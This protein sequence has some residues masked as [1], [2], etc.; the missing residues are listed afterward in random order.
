MARLQD[1]Y[2]HVR[3]LGNGSYG[4]VDLWR[5]RRFN[6]DFVVAKR[7]SIDGLTSEQEAAA[8][9]ESK[10]LR[11]LR[12]PHIVRYLS[13]W[14]DRAE[15]ELVIV[16]E[17]LSGGDLAKAIKA[18]GERQHRFEEARVL[19]WFAQL[20][21]ALQYC[22]AQSL[23]HRDL[24]P[25]NVFLSGDLDGAHLG[26][27]GV[28]KPLASGTGLTDTYV[29][30]H[31]YMSPEILQKGAYGLK[32]DVW[33]L[34]SIFYEVCALARPFETPEGTTFSTLEAIVSSEGPRP[35]P[36]ATGYQP[37]LEAM[38]RRMLDKSAASR[39]SLGQLLQQHTVLRTA[40]IQLEFRLGWEPS[41]MPEPEPEAAG[42]GA[43]DA[44]APDRGGESS[45]QDAKSDE[46]QSPATSSR[47]L[48]RRSS[49]D[50]DGQLSYLQLSETSKEVQELLEAHAR[51]PRTPT[52]RWPGTSCSREPEVAPEQRPDPQPPPDGA[53]DW[54]DL[55]EQLP[56][57]EPGSNGDLTASPATDLAQQPKPERRQLGNASPAAVAKADDCD[58]PT[59]PPLSRPRTGSLH[60]AGRIAA[61]GPSPQPHSAPWR[62]QR[63]A[64]EVPVWTPSPD[65]ELCGGAAASAL[66]RAQSRVGRSRQALDSP[67][68]NRTGAVVCRQ[69]GLGDDPGMQLAAPPMLARASSVPGRG[70]SA[71]TGEP[72]RLFGDGGAFFPP[73]LTTTTNA[74]PSRSV[75]ARSAMSSSVSMLTRRSQALASRTASPPMR[76]AGPAGRMR[77]ESALQRTVPFK[78]AGASPRRPGT[79][80]AAR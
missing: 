10:I 39:P 67:A 43:E 5:Q 2:D 57:D 72:P 8:R 49:E 60:S 53:V 14:V 62:R 23:I 78:A 20:W 22:H 77:L 76:S 69:R 45:T 24:K 7:I 36:A 29:G 73:S 68:L 50:L 70:P 79:G 33:G 51:P 21:H 55:L 52:L 47:A 27:F 13:S 12:H 19:R 61:A 11:G 54:S 58:T 32:S 71:P 64:A 40:V 37:A 80:L 16:Q 66:H 63:V 42:C 48:S 26:D 9:R 18:A 38:C 1:D 65:F 17:Y 59:P 4:I 31:L 28:S 30:T 6:C 34:G 44:C 35:F 74:A 46:P 25:N 3:R 56:L 15:G 75:L 41:L